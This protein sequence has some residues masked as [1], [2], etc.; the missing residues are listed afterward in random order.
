MTDVKVLFRAPTP[1]SFVDC[2][3]L[4]SLGLVPLPVSRHPPWQVSH[5]S[6]ISNIL[7]SP[8]QS[9]SNFIAS[10]SGFS[11]RPPFGDNPYTCLVSVAFFHNSFSSIYNMKGQLVCVFCPPFPVP[12]S[13][14]APEKINHTVYIS[15]KADWPIRSGFLLANSHILINPFF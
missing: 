11:S 3:T 1:F 14:Q 2:S 15:Y 4:L 13:Q 5:V 8:R 7:D 10:H 9:S 12:H 6:G